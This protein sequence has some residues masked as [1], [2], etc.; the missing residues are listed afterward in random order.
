MKNLVN[1]ILLLAVLAAQ[2]GAQTAQPAPAQGSGVG[3]STNKPKCG[4]HYGRS[5]AFLFCA[6][7]GW[8]L[9]NSTSYMD[10]VFASLY[11]EGSSW[12]SAK[13]SGTLMYITTFDK[14]N[15]KY[16][17]A[18]AMAFDAKDTK[19]SEKSVVVKQA[20]PIN[21]DDLSAPV[22]LFAPGP[23]NRFE[24]VAYIDSP[25]VIITFSMTSKDEDAFKRDYPAFVQF[26]QSYKFMS[27]NVTVQYK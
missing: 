5:H 10:G 27:S 17:I 18:K 3:I 26:V 15:D 11:Q 14:P 2:L 24:A 4:M 22:Q 16:T 9:D 20:D 25:K 6:P 12:E 21:L 1:G 13:Q 23:F 19:K 8:T 7:S